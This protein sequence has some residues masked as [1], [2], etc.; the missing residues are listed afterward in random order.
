[1]EEEKVDMKVTVVGPGQTKAIERAFLKVDGLVRKIGTKLPSTH[2]VNWGVD[3]YYLPLTAGKRVKVALYVDRNGFYEVTLV[4]S[5]K[6]I[7]SSW[8]KGLRIHAGYR[9]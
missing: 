2:G 1:M 3:N 4:G 8:R 6:K 5:D 7:L 9:S